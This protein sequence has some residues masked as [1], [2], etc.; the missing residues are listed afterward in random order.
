LCIT[1]RVLVRVKDLTVQKADDVVWVRARVHTSRAKG[2]IGLMVIALW[3]CIHFFLILM[4]ISVLPVVCLCV[5]MYM[6]RLRCLQS[7]KEGFGSPGVEGKVICELPNRI[8]VL[9]GMEHGS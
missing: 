6:Y 1:D 7:P 8:W 5:G 9:K 3:M 2:K 4:C